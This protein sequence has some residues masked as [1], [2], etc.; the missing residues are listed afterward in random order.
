MQNLSQRKRALFDHAEANGGEQYQGGKFNDAYRENDL[1]FMGFLIPPGKR[2]LELGCG[3]GDLLAS[4]R[5]AHGIGIDFSPRTIA[6]AR[7]LHPELQFVLGDAEDPATLD[8]IEG[9]FDDVVISDTIG[10][11]EDIDGTL[12]TLRN[13]CAPS[14]RIVI[15]YYSHL[16]EPILKLAKF[17]GLKRRQSQIN[18]I[19]AVDFLNL[20]DLADFEVV[21]MSSGN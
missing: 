3:R 20:M 9:P 1:R 6:S 21:R 13:L 2:V 15:S 7:T 12:R 14:T 8:G 18:Y 10:M 4:L 5:P 16:R 17:I 19:A 11:F